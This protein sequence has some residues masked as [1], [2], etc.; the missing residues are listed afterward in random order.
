MNETDG[1]QIFQALYPHL[2]AH[3]PVTVSFKDFVRMRSINIYNTYL[4]IA[5]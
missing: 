1:Y 5:D 3:Q 4:V 2:S